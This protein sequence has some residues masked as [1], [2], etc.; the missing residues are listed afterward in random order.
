MFVFSDHSFKGSHHDQKGT[1][2]L[3][4]RSISE[5]AS[6]RPRYLRP[7]YPE[8]SGTAPEYHSKS[9]CERGKK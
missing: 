2:Y 7:Y 4:S 8:I 9:A 3:F 6:R 1:G 5:T